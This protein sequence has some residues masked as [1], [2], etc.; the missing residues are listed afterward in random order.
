MIG[1][2]ALL[3]DSLPW[4][5][6]KTGRNACDP[7]AIR[8]RQREFRSIQYQE[9]NT[10][11]E[12][13][14]HRLLQVF[15]NLSGARIPGPLAIARSL[16]AI[17]CLARPSRTRST[18]ACRDSSRIRSVYPVCGKAYNGV[19]QK[20]NRRSNWTRPHLLWK[21]LFIGQR[22]NSQQG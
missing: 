14:C 3:S 6:D 11:F 16:N 1:R 17:S 15:H 13:E 8:V 7:V 4:T 2:S 20:G 10:E 18:P 22:K 21:H 9:Y 19:P 5:S 12:L